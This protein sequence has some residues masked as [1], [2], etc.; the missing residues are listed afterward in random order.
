MS[1]ISWIINDFF[2]ILVSIVISIL[3]RRLYFFKNHEKKWLLSDFSYFRKRLNDTNNELDKIR[4]IG[5][6]FKLHNIKRIKK[7]NDRKIQVEINLS[8][9]V[10]DIEGAI[11]IFMIHINRYE[12]IGGWFLLKAIA[13]FDNK[14]LASYSLFIYGCG[15]SFIISFGSYLLTSIFFKKIAPYFADCAETIFSYF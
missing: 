4:Y 3:S 13:N 6:G 9:R 15:L 7:L 11:F 2:I 1:S 14:N 12:L 10:G 8:K 5:S